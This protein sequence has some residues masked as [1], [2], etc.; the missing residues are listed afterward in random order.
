M[1][2][3]IA[4]KDIFWLEHNPERVLDGTG[5]ISV[6][7]EFIYIS[8]VLGGYVIAIMVQWSKLMRC[9]LSMQESSLLA[10]TNGDIKKRIPIVEHDELGSIASLTNQMLDTLE[11]AQDEVMATRDVAIVSL[12]ALAESRDNETGAHILRTQEYIRVLATHLSTFEQHK[13]LL[14]TSYIELL[15][16]SAPLH[17]VGKVGIPDNILLKPGKLT[18]EEFEIMKRHPEIGAQAL[19]M[20]E[21]QLGSNSFLRLAKE[22]SLTHHEKWDGNGYPNQLKGEEI[23][24]SGR[25]MA[26][27]DVYDALISERIYKK[28]FSHDKAKQ[29]IIEGSGS[30]FDPMIV[31][32]FVHLEQ[33]FINIA[34]KYRHMERE[35]N[36]QQELEQNSDI[37]TA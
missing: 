5:K 9:I 22:I 12:S 27:A 15:Y 26:V 35:E 23:P 24:L 36:L 18:D 25:L 16:K 17:D 37:V 4:V 8:L 7:K 32:A 30:H 33:E 28:A 19:S 21:K 20:A 34:N 14:S 10:I 29:I 3:M 13:P 2:A 11:S 1:L 6:I 31:D